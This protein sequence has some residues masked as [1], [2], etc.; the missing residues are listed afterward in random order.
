[1]MAYYEAYRLEEFSYTLGYQELNEEE[2]ARL[3]T[4]I[5]IKRGDVALLSQGLD[6][7]KDKAGESVSFTTPAPRRYSLFSSVHAIDYDSVSDSPRELEALDEEMTAQYREQYKTERARAE[8]IKA[9]YPSLNRLNI[10]QAVFNEDA[11]AALQRIGVRN[12]DAQKFMKEE[13]SFIDRQERDYETFQTATKV[14]LYA[15]SLPASL[16]AGGVITTAN[17]VIGGVDAALSVGKSVDLIF[18]GAEPSQI[19]KE[20]AMGEE[21]IGT[22]A[23]IMN[24]QW[25]LK[26]PKERDKDNI[27]FL[28]DA[29][30]KEFAPDTIKPQQLVVDIDQEKQAVA[31][32]TR[33]TP[34][35]TNGWPS[36]YDDKP[37]LRPSVKFTTNTKWWTDEQVKEHNVLIADMVQYLNAP[38]VQQ[39]TVDYLQKKISDAEQKNEDE[40]KAREMQKIIERKDAE[41]AAR[42]QRQKQQDLQKQAQNDTALA[43]DLAELG[44]TPDPEPQAEPTPLPPPIPSVP[45]VAPGEIISDCNLCRSNGMA[46]SCG[47]SAC[48][49]C[50]N[51]DDSCNAF[52]L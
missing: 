13:V 12:E 16:A 3:L 4:V 40:R 9:A 38:G 52:D 21:A 8:A 24:I 32:Y 6:Q 51:N 47:R 10:V 15:W 35:K 22:I 27:L 26:N 25:L 46:C 42:A 19:K 23:T 33:T 20:I 45:A 44:V 41:R 43:N 49:C 18:N 34:P 5:E 29:S 31:V 30:L 37:W 36:Y 28:V 14:T 1:M 50:P 11:Q 17:V 7:F 48:R 39:Y 2:F